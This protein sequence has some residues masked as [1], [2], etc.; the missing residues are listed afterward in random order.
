VVAERQAA[1]ADAA[2]TAAMLLERADKVRDALA[3][4]REARRSEPDPGAQLQRASRDLD[5][6][7]RT[8]QREQDKAHKAYGS[9]GERR[10][11]LKG[12]LDRLLQ[13]NAEQ[14]Q[15]LAQAVSASCRATEQ[16]RDDVSSVRARAH[17]P[18]YHPRLPCAHG[19]QLL[20]AAH[21]T[22]GSPSFRVRAWPGM[23]ARPGS[24]RPS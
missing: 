14:M 1:V 7:L 3:A 17:P 5:S 6:L 24:H 16:L 11:N 2:A 21:R 8:M 19:L 22:H 4:E 9:L 18:H 20:P 12:Q 23:C 10:E 13:T 15:I